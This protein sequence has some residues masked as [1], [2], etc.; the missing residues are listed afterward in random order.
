M[1]TYI[2]HLHGGHAVSQGAETVEARD[3][4]EACALAELRLT[5]SSALQNVEVERDGVEIRHLHC[6]GGH[7]R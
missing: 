3:D 1:P 7:P 5:L 6:E 2:F 4:E